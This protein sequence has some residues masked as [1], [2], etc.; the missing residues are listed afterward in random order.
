MVAAMRVGQEG[1][2]PVR[3]P[4][5]RHAGALG[6]P[7]ADDLFRIDVDLRPEAAADVVA[8]DRDVAGVDP[9]RAGEL[10][11]DAFWPVSMSYFEDESE[12]DGLPVY[13]IAFKL[14]ENGVTRDLTM[15]YGDFV[16]EGQLAQLDL[17]EPE[18]CPEQ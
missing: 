3:V 5:H 11:D 10:A 1:L 12:G 17:Y 14:Y 2:R 16:L 13:S 7:K 4:F 9:E 15:D 6:R 18:P 8:G